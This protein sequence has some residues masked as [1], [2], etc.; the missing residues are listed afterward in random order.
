VFSQTAITD[1]NYIS[2]LINIRDGG[3][4]PGSSYSRGGEIIK[5]SIELSSHPPR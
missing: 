1:N 4:Q 2:I 5:Q 3:A